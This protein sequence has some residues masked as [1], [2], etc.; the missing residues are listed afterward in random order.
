MEHENPLQTQQ[1]HCREATPEEMAEYNRQADA[2]ER[3]HFGLGIVEE[4]QPEAER[5]RPP[6]ADADADQPLIVD[7]TKCG[8]N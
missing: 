5:R 7:K 1:K 4:P 2:A 3:Y 6:Q 8:E